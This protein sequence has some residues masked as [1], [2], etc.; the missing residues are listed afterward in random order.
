[1]EVF[2]VAAGRRKALIANP[3][4][5]D[6]EVYQRNPAAANQATRSCSQ[7]SGQACLFGPTLRPAPG[8]DAA[9]PV[10]RA[11]TLRHNARVPKL[12]RGG[13]N[14]RTVAPDVLAEP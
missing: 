14:L 10:M 9:A 5:I 4:G 8:V 7:P 6:I 11:K 12:F 13:E 2:E 1:M 3:D